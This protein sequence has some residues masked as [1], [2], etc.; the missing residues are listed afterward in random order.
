MTKTITIDQNA[1]DILLWAKKESRTQGID[2]PDHSEAIRFMKNKIDELSKIKN[3]VDE[4]S[5][6]K[7]NFAPYLQ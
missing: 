2:N 4:L 1:Y 3:G 6:K 7:K 5:G